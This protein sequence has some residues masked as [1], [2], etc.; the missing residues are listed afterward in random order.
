MLVIAREF[1]AFFDFT[2][3]PLSLT[4][5]FYWVIWG[6]SLLKQFVTQNISRTRTREPIPF[7]EPPRSSFLATLKSPR[8]GHRGRLAGKEA[9]KRAYKEQEMSSQDPLTAL[10]M[11]LQ[12]ATEIVA[13][14]KIESAKASAIARSAGKAERVEAAANAAELR[15]KAAASAKVVKAIEAKISKIE[16]DRERAEKKAERERDLQKKKDQ[17]AADKAEAKA[18]K[19]QEKAQK[20]EAAIAYK[21]QRMD[22]ARE[23]P[24]LAFDVDWP[25]LAAWAAP[26]LEG[27]V[28]YVEGAGWG[29]WSGVCWVFA[30]RLADAAAL[31]DM[32]RELYCLEETDVVV[33][34]NANP[35]SAEHILTHAKDILS[36]DRWMFNSPAVAHLIPFQNVTVDLKTGETMPHDPEHYMTGAIQCDYNPDAN[37]D[38]VKEAFARFWPNDEDTARVFQLAL[39]YSM[40]GEV[41]AKRMF[42]MVGNQDDATSNG[43]NGK[44]M[45][46]NALT[47]LF[48]FGRGG[49]GVAIKSSIIV[50]TGDRDANSHDAAK[51]P[52]IWKR[53]AMASEFR[54]GASIN[55]GE[56]NVLSGGDV[57]TARAPHSPESIQFI[58][59]SSDWFSMNQVARFKSWDKATKHRLTPFP[60]NQ[61]FF[62]PGSEELENGGQSA[63]L[64]LKPWLESK[65]GQEALGAYLVE[66]AMQYYAGNSGVAGDWV[67][68]EAMDELKEQILDAS[69]PY[70]EFFEEMLEFD[71]TMSTDRKAFNAVLKGCLGALKQHEKAEFKRAMAGKGA[72]EKKVKGYYRWCG[73]ALSEDARKMAALSGHKTP[74]YR[75]TRLRAV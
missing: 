14:D 33:K 68:S 41:A 13:A 10:R 30:P 39:G 66:G 2:F 38:R 1:R 29:L 15:E 65:A 9:G 22:A 42:M 44:S 25:A 28:C 36:V 61:A 62:K 48:G 12:A 6:I 40:T 54:V 64:S 72:V 49:F 46:Q 58:N 19:E 74:C 31:L 43:D 73:V 70:R 11:E 63:D 23:N 59:I 50:D 67:D 24:L 7:Q 69:N 34:L 51:G 71:K 21:K 53:F 45:V 52:L 3:R 18:A 37:I 32:V 8:S 47:K 16:K 75:A 55:A 17:A 35:R 5:W 27:L 60:F 20:I 57:I 26:Q 56:F 4:H